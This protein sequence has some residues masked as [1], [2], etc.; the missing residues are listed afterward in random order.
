MG[1]VRKATASIESALP[2]ITYKGN[3]VGINSTVGAVKTAAADV[4]K[5]IEQAAAVGASVFLSTITGMPITPDMVDQAA[6]S[7]KK[8]TYGKTSTA[9]LPAIATQPM[10][11]PADQAVVDKG[12]VVGIVTLI[13]VGV[14]VW[15][16]V[17]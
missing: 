12:T 14:I 9:T 6:T 10:A 5:P 16:L 1:A 13:V 3:A 2:K 11:T 8:E 7:I 15:K 4:A 17:K